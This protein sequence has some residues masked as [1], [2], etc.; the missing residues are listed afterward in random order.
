MLTVKGIFEQGTARPIGKVKGR[1]GQSVIITFLD[2]IVGSEAAGEDETDQAWHAFSEL[3]ESCMV[4]TGI[5]NLADRHDDYL[6]H[7]PQES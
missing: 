7:K 3:V 4:E 1:E 5:V 2:D 6:H